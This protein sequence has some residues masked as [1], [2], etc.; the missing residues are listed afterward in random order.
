MTLPTVVGMIPSVNDNASSPPAAPITTALLT[1]WIG[2]EVEL[3]LVQTPPIFG[4]V[5]VSGWFDLLKSSRK[6]VPP[7]LEDV[8][9][10][11]AMNPIT[12]QH[13]KERSI[14]PSKYRS[15]GNLFCLTQ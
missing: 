8:A 11:I 5:P 3:T 10:R 12:A 9:D 13:I 6:T 7:R 4:V 15:L 14:N 1:I 2:F